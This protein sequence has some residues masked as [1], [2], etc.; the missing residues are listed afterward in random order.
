MN[1]LVFRHLGTKVSLTWVLGPHGTDASVPRSRPRL[2]RAC[3]A[4]I[5]VRK[6]AQVGMGI[7]SP[8]GAPCIELSYAW[9]S[10]A[11]TISRPK[12]VST[13]SERH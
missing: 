2:R 5:G 11:R 6:P 3:K 9:W 8:P 7:K 10:E 4:A 13:L 12:A 1:E